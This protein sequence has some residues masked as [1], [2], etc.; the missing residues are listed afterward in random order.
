MSTTIN[1]TGL[2]AA[3]HLNAELSNFHTWVIQIEECIIGKG[4]KGY[5]DGTIIRPKVVQTSSQTPIVDTPIYSLNPS[6]AEFIY[7]DGIA[8]SILI[9]SIL[10]PVTAGVDRTGTTHKCW[11]S[12]LET[13]SPQS[14]AMISLVSR[15]L[16]TTFMTDDTSVQNVQNHITEMKGLRHKLNELGKNLTDKDFQGHLIRSLPATTEWMGISGSLHRQSLS[17]CIADI[18]TNA[19]TINGFRSRPKV[20]TGA[21]ATSSN[22]PTRRCSNP[23]CK[24]RNRTS[25]VITDCYWPG[26]G[27]EG[28]FPSNFG[29]RNG[30]PQ[31]NITTISSSPGASIAYSP[32]YALSAVSRACGFDWADEPCGIEV[33]IGGSDEDVCMRIEKCPSATV[34]E[35]GDKD[36]G[37]VYECLSEDSTYVLEAIQE[38]VAYVTVAQPHFPQPTS[39]APLDS[40]ATDHFFRHREAFS[41]YKEIPT[42]FGHAAQSGDG[43]P[44]VGRG[45]VTRNIHTDGKWATVTFRN[46]LHAPTLASDLIS[47]S[48]LDKAGCTTIF[49]TNKA[50][51]TKGRQQLFGASINNNI[52][53]VNMEPIPGAFLSTSTPA[54][55]CQWHRRL[56][57]GSAEVIKTMADKDL[58]DGLSITSRET[59]GKCVDCILARQTTRPYDKPSDPDV[60]PLEL[61]AFDLWG[62]SRIPTD[63]GNIYMMAIVD[64]G[65][66]T[67]AAEFLPNKGDTATIA[68]FDRYR[69]TAEAESGKRIRT[70]LTDNAFVSKAWEDYFTS[71]DIHHVTTTPYSSAQNGLAERAIRQITEDMRANLRDS[72]LG[73][74]YWAHAADHSTYTRN[75]IPSRRH[76]NRIPREILTGK[77]QDI[78]HLRVFG[79]RCWCKVPVINGHQV[80]GGDKIDNRG[81]ECIF[82][83]YAPGSGNYICQDKQGRI[84]DSRT[85]TF[86]EGV[87]H[88]TRDSDEIEFTNISPSP[89]SPAPDSPPP[90][91][92]ETSE[93]LPK[94]DI[95]PPTSDNAPRNRRSRAEIWGTIPTR[96][97]PR[98]NPVVEETN[99]AANTAMTDPISQLSGELD[100]CIVLL[101]SDPMTISVPKSYSEAIRVDK[102]RWFSA[103]DVE[104]DNHREKGTWELVDPPPGAN[105]MDCRWVYDIKLDGHGKWIRDK[106]RLVGKGFTQQLGVDYT[107]TWAAVSRMESIRMVAAVAA[108]LDLKLWQIDFIAAYLNSTPE[109]DIYMRQPPGY[110]VP[111]HENSVCHLKKT[112]YGTM[113]GAY[114]WARTLDAGFTSI[115][116]QA[117]KADPCVRVK[118]SGSNLTLTATYTDDVW[119]ASTTSELGEEAKKELGRLWDIKDV[120]ENHRLLGMR[121]DQDLD[122]GTVTLSQ[123]AYFEQVLTR[124]KLNNITPRNTPL[125]IGIQLNADMA[126]ITETEKR[127]MK[128]KPYREVLG[129]VM[130]CQLA[131][132]PD[133]S[134]TVGLLS[135]FQSN[136]GIEHW[137]ALMHVVG[138][139]K[140]TIDYGIVFSRDCPLK[141]FGYV[142]ASY[143]DDPDTRRS[144]SGQVFIMAGGPVSWSSKRQATVALSTVEAEYVSLS[145]GAQQLRWMFAWMEE[146][147]MEQ[148]RPGHLKGDNEGSVSLTKNTHGHHRVKHIDLRL[149]YIRELVASK[150]ITVD[151]IRGTENPADLFTKPLP[152]DTHYRYLKDLNI[153]QITT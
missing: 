119:G 121:V 18:I 94:P 124:F 24:A 117:S 13:C 147:G 19:I 77:R 32:H 6:L 96:S 81:E 78:S 17:N 68:A 46:A 57:H 69:V 62:P 92:P 37:R 58:V 99:A 129:C 143:G 56:A 139:I 29:K 131:T 47:V 103:M 95:I 64:S 133:L 73:P 11:T 60:D 108:S 33:R 86:E 149:H 153:I 49:E 26:G 54:S 35:T 85:V 88:R 45:S 8:R 51:V 150:E 72:G 22:S 31:S 40:G 79:S 97:S 43:F 109:V 21:L 53:C 27:K 63:A 148:E 70:V 65:S 23:Q 15:Q 34:E 76:P 75:Y 93:Q 39:S 123:R 87:P 4:L 116:Y 12:V 50:T 136:P 28:Q 90:H 9:N 112:L 89:P 61:V 3:H 125:P 140:N 48:Q 42:R 20:H 115:G 101:S 107:E 128:D 52:Y 105:I 84:I 7:R 141:P 82:L 74:S 106:A 113:Q 110:I 30:T 142:D 55:L 41:D 127:E 44:I 5:L 151:S 102:P 59:P 25:H 135:R 66:G 67:H 16:E 98:L 91:T 111:G 118:R 138:Y 152:R 146:I 83:G 145:R 14:D 134:F 126:P 80:D 122:K 120:G 130:W 100:D 114:D 1:S 2:N 71:H 10:D 104:M 36:D 38:A 137:K 132:R 144:T